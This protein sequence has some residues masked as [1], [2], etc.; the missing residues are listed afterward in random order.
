MMQF[1]T[2]LFASVI[3]LGRAGE[4]WKASAACAR[5][6]APQAAT[7]ILRSA[8]CKPDESR[9]WS[10]SGDWPGSLTGER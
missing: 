10:A 2:M 8:W 4:R 9:M 7:S 5:I 1:E 3:H 6:P